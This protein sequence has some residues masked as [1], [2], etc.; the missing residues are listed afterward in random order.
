M[1]SWEISVKGSACWSGDCVAVEVL[2]GVEVSACW[3]GD[4]AGI[5]VLAGIEVSAGDE[6][7][8][9]EIGEGVL[10]GTVQAVRTRKTPNKPDE[11]W[12]RRFIMFPS[13]S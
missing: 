9:F 4:C 1:L 5:V 12:E 3:S 11:I 2:A 7:T 10:S 13:S 6:V 8:G